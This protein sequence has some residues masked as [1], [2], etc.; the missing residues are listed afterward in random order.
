METADFLS[1]NL[2]FTLNSQ[3][4]TDITQQAIEKSKQFLEELGKIPQEKCNFSTIMLPMLEHDG[5]FG[6]ISASIV[7]PSRVSLTREVRDASSD[8]TQK[9]SDH[10]IEVG[11]REDLFKVVQWAKENEEKMNSQLDD[12]S[13]RA[14]E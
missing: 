13:K 12:E 11:K 2:N 14:L 8:A 7:N 9:I 1:K 5:D 4:I 6:R 10:F 3:Q